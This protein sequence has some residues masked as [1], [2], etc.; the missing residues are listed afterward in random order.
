[1]PHPGLDVFDPSLQRR[2]LLIERG[3]T[4][5]AGHVW[6][7]EESAV[8]CRPRAHRPPAPPITP[9][10]RE[11]PPPLP[12]PLPPGGE[13]AAPA[14]TEGIEEVRDLLNGAGDQFDVLAVRPV[15]VN[16]A[17]D[18]VF[19]NRHG[20]VSWQQPCFPPISED[21]CARTTFPEAGR[22]GQPLPF[23]LLSMRD[24][25]P[26]SVTASRRN[27]NLEVACN[28]DIIRRARLL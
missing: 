22:E 14:P 12:S 13:R 27:R 23:P 24:A 10:C 2:Q 17:L 20:R 11:G 8:K 4:G 15:L 7:S 3:Q 21:A 25:A 19:L 28:A 1:M 6:E 26:T 9:I 5:A 16:L 18:R